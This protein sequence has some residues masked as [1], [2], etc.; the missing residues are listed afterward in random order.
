MS[1]FGFQEW[2]YKLEDNIQKELDFWYKKLDE[3]KRP[4]VN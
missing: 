2:I 3:K 1:D 4:R